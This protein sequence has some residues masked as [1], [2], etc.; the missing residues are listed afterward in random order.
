MWRSKPPPPCF[1]WAPSPANAGEDTHPLRTV[2]RTPARRR[3]GG[4]PAGPA[5]DGQASPVDPGPHG[6]PRKR[7]NPP[8]RAS[9][10]GSHPCRGAGCQ[11]CAVGDGGGGKMRLPLSRD[12]RIVGRSASARFHRHTAACGRFGAQ[13]HALLAGAARRHCEPQR[14]TNALADRERAFA[15]QRAGPESAGAAR[16]GCRAVPGTWGCA[17]TVEHR[18]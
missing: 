1:A 12:W 4:V 7:S 17:G 13:R 18:A 10:A 5:R 16:L 11:G 9:H 15:G 2:R 3:L 6:D 14:R 8:T